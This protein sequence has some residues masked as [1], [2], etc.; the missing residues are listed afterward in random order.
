MLVK[1]FALCD[2]CARRQGDDGD[3]GKGDTS[4][5]TI[6]PSSKVKGCFICHGLT[7][8]VGS[9]EP[10]VIRSVRRYQF[11][12]FSIGM[13]IP[14]GVQER[15][16]QLR[17][18]LR[19]RGKETI[20]SQLAREI[21]GSI[22][23]NDKG[24][25]LDRLRPDITIL[26][27]LDRN[28][29]GVTAKSVF[30]YG[31]Y[32]KPRGISQRRVLCERCDGRGCEDCRGTGYSEVASIE[33]VVGR[34]LGEILRSP[35]TKFTWLG[36]EDIESLV[37]PPGRPFVIEMKN[38]MNRRPPRQFTV[39]TGKGLARV[40]RLKTLRGKPTSVPTFKFA[41]RAFVTSETPIDL[42]VT[43]PAKMRNTLVQ[44]INNKDKILYKKV[45]SLQYKM[46]GKKDM[47]ADIKLDGGLPVKRLV[48]GESVFPSL[49]E[50]FKTPLIC[51]RFDILKVWVSGDFKFGDGP[52]T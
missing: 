31:M 19:I 27:D 13:I 7:G 40:S 39:R 18:E 14:S 10:K 4:I 51:R 25:K 49:S 43:G 32:T 36:S 41:T 22:I 17:S 30:V 44:Y 46:R 42:D 6:L 15:E 50:L 21:A 45:Y 37:L 16:D 48:S 23:A 2:P 34:K 33:D 38:P 11:K 1:R 20:K 8:K 28:V 47:V 26:V 52:Q 24:K 12:T 5:I 3:S 9:L 35:R 29:I